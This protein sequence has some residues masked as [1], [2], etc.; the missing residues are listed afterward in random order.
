MAIFSGVILALAGLAFQIA[1]RS[2]RATDQALQMGRLFSKVDIASVVPF[3]SLP[4]LAGCDTIPSGTVIAIS[5]V[6]VTTLSP[7]TRSIGIVLR[8]S[9]PGSQPDTIVIFRSRE[10]APIPLR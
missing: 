5:C 7:R 6:T 3:D 9:V 1:R 8:T 10:R 4:A 2:S